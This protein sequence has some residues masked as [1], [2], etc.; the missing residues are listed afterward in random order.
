MALRGSRQMGLSLDDMIKKKP[1]KSI[2]AIE[3]EN[4]SQDI[5][6]RKTFVSFPGMQI[7]ETYINMKLLDNWLHD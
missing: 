1:I 4:I 2:Y 5:L 3:I 6:N 7:G